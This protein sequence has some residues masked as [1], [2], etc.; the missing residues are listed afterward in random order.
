MGFNWIVT[1]SMSPSTVE[2]EPSSM[3]SGAA[4]GTAENAIAVLS[5]RGDPYRIDAIIASAVDRRE[6]AALDLNKVTAP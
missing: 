2:V 4:V 3:F 1:N 6:I 5:V